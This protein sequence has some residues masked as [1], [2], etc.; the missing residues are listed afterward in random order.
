VDV[1]DSA[2]GAAVLN[3]CKY[4]A[5]VD[6]SDVGLSL[7]RAPTEPDPEADRG[8]HEFSYALRPHDGSLQDGGVVE[9]GYEFNVP[10]RAVP[11]DD[12]VNFT[13][14][15]IDAEGVVIESVKRA[16]DDPDALVVRC[17]EAYGRSIEATLDPGFPVADAARVSIVEDE[18]ESLSVEDGIDLSLDAFEIE[19]I[20]LTPA[21]H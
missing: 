14:P 7:L 11:V 6:G 16:E 13:G 2:S 15:T 8:R 4:G 17:Y 5:N 1:T 21:D 9:A 3:D 18:R 12:A 19:S 20:H 10:A